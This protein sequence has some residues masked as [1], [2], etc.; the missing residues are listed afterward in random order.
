MQKSIILK[1]QELYNEVW[2]TPLTKLAELYNLSDNG[3]R[4]ICIKLDI[5]LPPA[6]YWV[7]VKYGKK[8]KLIPLPN[9]KPNSLSEYI[10]NPRAEIIK[11][12]R[13]TN[14]PEIKIIDNVM[15]H[16][17]I[18]KNTLDRLKGNYSI[19]WSNTIALNFSENTKKRGLLIL[20]TIFS[21]L[22][23][24]GY[25]IEIDSSRR[26]NCPCAFDNNI[27]IGFD[28]RERTFMK[29]IENARPFYDNK[30]E[31]VFNGLLELRLDIWGHD[32]KK[33]FTDNPKNKVEDYLPEFIHNMI[34][35]FQQKK[36]DQI[37]EV[38]RRE[39]RAKSERLA[40]IERRKNEEE[41]R[42]ADILQN[43]A[44]QL[45][46]Y[47]SVKELLAQIRIKYESDIIV[48]EKLNNWIT[49][50]EQANENRDPIKSLK[51]LIKFE[52]K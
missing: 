14:L 13:P 45:K 37:R 46:I 25:K 33:V 16:H 1:R 48:N 22:E 18:L 51:F 50:A 4:K 40:E 10:L 17:V 30:I 15:R 44:S 43:M 2:S 5:P 20:E 11:I 41:H 9:L 28:L 21:E 42:K 39:D 12:I 47:N 23:E 7:K 52:S 24:R 31:N 27:R 26:N 32:L 6:G 3:L 38:A 49:W 36:D 19:P 35:G 29:K 34:L 8:V